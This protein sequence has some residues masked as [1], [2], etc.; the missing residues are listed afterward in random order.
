M[1]T[2]LSN[3]RRPA[4]RDQLSEAMI[5][6]R[7]RGVRIGCRFRMLLVMKYTVPGFEKRPLRRAAEWGCFADIVVFRHK[8]VAGATRSHAR[9]AR[10]IMRRSGSHPRLSAA[11]PASSLH[12]L[13]SDLRRL[14]SG[15]TPAH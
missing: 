4:A 15:L 5:M 10:F 2:Y 7:A 3:Q 13:T 6:S 11:S 9:Q 12:L 14:P 8:T 1:T